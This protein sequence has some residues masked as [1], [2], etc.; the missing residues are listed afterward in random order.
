MQVGTVTYR[1]PDVLD[2]F[3]CWML[4]QVLRIKG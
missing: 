4:H 1:P 2:V 3:S